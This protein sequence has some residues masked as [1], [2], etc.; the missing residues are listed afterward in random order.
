M[1]IKAASLTITLL[2][3]ALGSVACSSSDSTSDG[4]GSAGDGGSA[5]SGI[6]G[7]SGAAGVSGVGGTTASGGASAGGAAGKAGSSG[8]SGG[9]GGAGG[10]GGSGVPAGCTEIHLKSIVFDT[11]NSNDVA[12]LFRAPLSTSLGDP[13]VIDGMTITIASPDGS[14]LSKTGAF[15]LGQGTESNYST[16]GHCLVVVQDA[17]SAAS[18]KFFPTAG[19]FNIDAS[20]PP[21]DAA[22][23]GLKG[24]LVGVELHEATISP[25]A[26]FTSTFVPGGGCVYFTN[27][28]LNVP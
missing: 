1:T 28:T 3:A 4:T 15:T 11:A 21:V 2:F 9:A 8:S 14:V 24:S 26:P 18:R 20:T 7:A 17:G 13:S 6:A 23:K 5:G 27:E 12:S 22:T 25:A 10:A 16:C 19:T